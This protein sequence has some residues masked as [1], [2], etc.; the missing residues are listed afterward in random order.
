[1]S[2]I[3]GGGAGATELEVFIMAAKAPGGGLP[4]GVV[5]TPEARKVLVSKLGGDESMR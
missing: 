4:G 3:A 1:M 5:E 2:G